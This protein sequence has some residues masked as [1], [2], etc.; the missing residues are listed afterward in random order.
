MTCPTA[1][2]GTI[3]WAGDIDPKVP[4][5]TESFTMEYTKKGF[6]HCEYNEGEDTKSKK[7]YFYV[8]GKG[9]L[10]KKVTISYHLP[11]M[12]V[13]L[14]DLSLAPPLCFDPQRVKTVLNWT[15]S[16]F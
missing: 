13:V 4:N 16:C 3:K 7:Y 6:Y 8:Q 12:S 5:D 15:R 11:S 14:T 9:E 10:K 1:D 2:V